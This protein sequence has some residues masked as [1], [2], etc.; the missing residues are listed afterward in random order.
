M[1]EKKDIIQDDTV[2]ENVVVPEQHAPTSTVM[3]QELPVGELVKEGELNGNS[4]P[5]L[6]P[7][8]ITLF[9][10]PKG[11]TL[12]HGSP[13]LK[14]FNPKVINIGNDSLVAFFSPNKDIASMYIKKCM[15]DENGKIEG[16]VHEF[17][18]I[19]DIKKI[20]V[21]SPDDKDLLWK[22]KVIEDKFCNGGTYGKLDGVGFAVP[23]KEKGKFVNDTISFP[24][25]KE[26]CE[27]AL[28]NPSADILRYV[29]TFRCDGPSKLSDAYRFTSTTPEMLS[30]TSP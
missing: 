5:H 16:Y 6:E 14:Q 30:A 12:Y 19:V 17:V 4:L 9:T 1:E 26:S 11:T 20:F 23:D 7:S 2:V 22:T 15:A 13:N 25:D 27:F 3:L 29:N 18:T 8:H 24:D 10:I 21:F 28:C